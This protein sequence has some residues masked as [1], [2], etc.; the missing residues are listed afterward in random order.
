L[1]DGNSW[2]PKVLVEPRDSNDVVKKFMLL[3]RQSYGPDR[4]YRISP[5]LPEREAAELEKLSLL[6]E[7]V[8]VA[9][10]SPIGLVP[11][12][13]FPNNRLTYLG[14][15]DCGPYG[16]FVYSNDL[17]SVRKRFEELLSNSPIAAS[18]EHVEEEI[19]KLALRV[20]NGILRIGRSDSQVLAQVGLMAA[21]YFAGES[22]T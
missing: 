1:E 16:M 6:A 4:L 9:T 2:V 20:P 22:R 15:E 18:P 13:T 14:R 11:P 19:K 5:M 12:R 8:I 21:S 3:A 10:P 7:W 17:F